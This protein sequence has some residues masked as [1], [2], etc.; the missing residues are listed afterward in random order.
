MRVE[1][2]RHQDHLLRLG[3]G[4]HQRLQLLGKVQGC[5]PLRHAHL[6]PTRERLHPQE[7]VAGTAALV[8]IV[9]TPGLAWFQGQGAMWGGMEFLA[10][11]VQAHH[12]TLGIVGPLVHCQHVFHLGDEAGRELTEAPGLHL[13]GFEFIF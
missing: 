6:T 10:L 13:P 5:A 3:I 8:L 1:V 9:F 11:L 4:R 12:G 7:Q 2:V